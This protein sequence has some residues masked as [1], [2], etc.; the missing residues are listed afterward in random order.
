M[1]LDNSYCLKDVL[2]LLAI[3]F[4]RVLMRSEDSFTMGSCT[5]I[6]RVFVG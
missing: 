3:G 2:T 4:A 6:L 1:A 5:T